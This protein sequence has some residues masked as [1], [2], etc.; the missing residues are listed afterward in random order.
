MQN[1]V[2]KWCFWTT[3]PTDGTKSQPDQHVAQVKATARLLTKLVRQAGYVRDYR[4]RSL[5]FVSASASSVLSATVEIMPRLKP[6]K[7]ANPLRSD[8]RLHRAWH[9]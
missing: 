2:W 7:H 3:I 6:S 1:Q 4:L 8:Q 9:H 5:P